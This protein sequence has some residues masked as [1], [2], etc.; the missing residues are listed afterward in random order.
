LAAVQQRLKE[1][2]HH[3]IPEGAVTLGEISSYGDG[4]LESFNKTCVIGLLHE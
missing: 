4:Y 2:G 1:H 3:C